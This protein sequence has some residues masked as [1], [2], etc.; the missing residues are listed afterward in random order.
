MMGNCGAGQ[1]MGRQMCTDE[2]ISW[3][4]ALAVNGHMGA[5]KV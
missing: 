2:K 5:K 3:W 1:W 4:C